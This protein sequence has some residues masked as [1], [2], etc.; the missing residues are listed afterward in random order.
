VPPACLVGV[1][2]ALGASWVRPGTDSLCPSPYWLEP[3]VIHFLTFAL[4]WAVF[5]SLL[6]TAFLWAVLLSLPQNMTSTTQPTLRIGSFNAG[7]EQSS[8]TGRNRKKVMDKTS[9]VITLCVRAH[10][11]HMFSLCELG[12]HRQ[13]L[14]EADLVYRDMNK[15][16]Q[17]QMRC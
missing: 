5:F 9:D 6:W 15:L 10:N 17:I 13:G 7:V 4:H 14:E 1:S 12:G 3:S 8:L 11:L 16:W 2:W